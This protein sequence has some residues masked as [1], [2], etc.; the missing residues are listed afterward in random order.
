MLKMI[1]TIF[2]IT[3]IAGFLAGCNTVHGFGRDVEAT[4]DAISNS[5]R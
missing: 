5:S 3:L 4:G 2:V 1:K